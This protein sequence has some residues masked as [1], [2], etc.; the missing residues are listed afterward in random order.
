MPSTMSLSEEMD[1]TSSIEDCT[2]YWEHLQERITEH[3][4]PSYEALRGY[5]QAVE[6]VVIFWPGDLRTR[7]EVD[8]MVV[9]LRLA[10]LQSERMFYS[11]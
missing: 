3:N 7:K 11:R 6:L 8:N 5:L 2:E 10:V 1:G 4:D 9:R